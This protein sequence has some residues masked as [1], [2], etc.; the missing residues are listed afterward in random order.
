VPANVSGR[1]V[2]ENGDPVSGALVE[3][4]FNGWSYGGTPLD[5][6]IA[7]PPVVAFGDAAGNI[8]APVPEPA[9]DDGRNQ[10]GESAPG[11]M[12][13]DSDTAAG[14]AGGS[15]SDPA[16]NLLMQRFRF[17]NQNGRGTS[18]LEGFNGYVSVVTGADGT[19]EFQ[20]IPAGDSYFFAGG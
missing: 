6:D 8:G 3:F 9:F 11:S 16:D 14:G 17:E 12:A 20:N 15:W 13:P 5:G 4:I 18:D 1:V 7:V 10:T 19:F 2:N